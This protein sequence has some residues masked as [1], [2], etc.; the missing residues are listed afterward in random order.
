MESRPYFIFGDVLVNAAA[1][2]AAALFVHAIVPGSWHPLVSM[3]LGMAGGALAASAVAFLFMPLF[4]A[5]EVMLPAMLTGMLAGMA[6]PVL[7]APAL[8]GALVGVAVVGWVY[9]LT[10]YARCRD[11]R[12]RRA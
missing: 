8:P 12:A 2:V 5:F 11:E 1:G 10:A 7:E 6:G 9:L 3:T 4:G